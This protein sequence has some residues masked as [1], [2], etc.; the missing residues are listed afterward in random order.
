MED[1]RFRRNRTSEAWRPLRRNVSPT[2][3]L[4]TEAKMREEIEIGSENGMIRRFQPPPV[5]ILRVTGAILRRRPLDAY[6]E[7]YLPST[8]AVDI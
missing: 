1:T 8:H 3:S 4:G 5:V 2:S 6:Q 7:M